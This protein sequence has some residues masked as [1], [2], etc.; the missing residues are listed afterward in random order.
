MYTEDI[1]NTEPSALTVDYFTFS[2]YVFA[3]ST[4]LGLSV[5]TLATWPAVTYQLIINIPSG[6]DITNALCSSNIT[7]LGCS[8]FAPTNTLTVSMTNSASLPVKIIF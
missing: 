3:E 5:T 4:D 1:I 6:L 2:S 8:F 7:N